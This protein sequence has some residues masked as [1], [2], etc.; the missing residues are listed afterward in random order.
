MMDDEAEISADEIELL[1]R[2][3][4]E[5]ALQ[6]EYLHEKFH[7][8]GTGNATLAKIASVLNRP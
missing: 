7:E 3:L 5:A 8:T 2:T 6:I 4:H 1:R